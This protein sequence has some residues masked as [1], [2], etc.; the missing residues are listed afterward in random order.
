MMRA[1]VLLISLCPTFLCAAIDNQQPSGADWLTFVMSLKGAAGLGALGM[2]GA[3]VQGLLLIFRS[4]FV[5]LSGAKKL[6]I[7]QSLSIVFGVLSLRLNGFD[8]ASSFLHANTLGAIQVF[9]NQ[10]LKQFGGKTP[11]SEKAA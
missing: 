9:G 10:L 11:E 2:A 4:D 6:A 7:V 8:W 5:K 1:I 3:A